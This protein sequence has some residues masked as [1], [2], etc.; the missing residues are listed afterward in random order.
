MEGCR[1]E[2]TLTPDD[3]ASTHVQ[4]VVNEDI[5]SGIAQINLDGRE[6]NLL[7]LFAEPKCLR[8]RPQ[9]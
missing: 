5:S 4:V 9:K 8:V 1:D 7:K 2:L 3:L 6:A